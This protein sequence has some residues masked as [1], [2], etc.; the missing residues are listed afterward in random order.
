MHASDAADGRQSPLEELTG[1]KDAHP[2]EDES[3]P[4]T[5]PSTAADETSETHEDD[6]S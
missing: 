5:G 3:R 2:E 6:E 1:E 4:E